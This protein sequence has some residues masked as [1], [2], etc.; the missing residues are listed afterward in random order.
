MPWDCSSKNDRAVIVFFVGK[1]NGAARYAGAVGQ[2]RFMDMVAVVTLAA[3]GR[4][5]RLGFFVLC[6]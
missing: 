6:H 1:V 3:K 4:D 5:Q 2:D